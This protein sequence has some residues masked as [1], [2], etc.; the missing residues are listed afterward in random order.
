M[1]KLFTLPWAIGI[2][3]L[4]ACS[5]NNDEPE[6]EQ[7]SVENPSSVETDPPN[8][9]YSPAFSGQTRVNATRTTTAYS[10]RVVTTA[11]TA[12]WGITSLP[13]GRLLITQKGGTMRIVTTSGQVGSPITGIHTVN[14][15]GQGGLL[16]LCID[17]DFD[18]NRMVYWVFSEPGSNGNLTAVAKGRLSDDEA[19]IENA[20]V[21]Y[22]A[23]PG[24][25]GTAHYGGRILFD[26]TGNLL[27]S[28]GERSDLSTRPLAQSLNAS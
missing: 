13:D 26:A 8:T 1:K 7:P 3:L 17:P 27:V 12:P 5:S 25:S 16:G 21:I 6:A 10:S 22:R 11:L 20:T 14:S 15:G 24:Y 18:T 28:T 19:T 4:A 23:T 9:S 2:L